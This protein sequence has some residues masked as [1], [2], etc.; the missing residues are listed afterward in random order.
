MTSRTYQWTTE[1]PRDQ[2]QF[3]HTMVRIYNKFTQGRSPQLINF[4]LNDPPPGEL[5][6]LLSLVEYQVDKGQNY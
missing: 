4:E 5:H 2:T 3:L 1:K 6:R